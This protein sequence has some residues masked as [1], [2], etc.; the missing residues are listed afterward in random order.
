[1]PRLKRAVGGLTAVLLGVGVLPAALAPQATAAVGQGF[2]LNPSDLR[3]ILKQIK[4]SEQHAATAT[5]T[6]PCGT[7][8]GTGPDQIPNQNC[9]GAELPWGLRTVDGTLQQPQARPGDVRRR[10]PDLPADLVPEFRDADD[11]DPDGPGRAPDTDSYTSRPGSSS[12]PSRARS[13]N[14]IVDQ[15]TDQPRRGRRRRRGPARPDDGTLFIPN[16]APDVGLSAPYNSWFTLFGQFFDHGLDLTNK[17]GGTVF[18]PLEHRRPAVR[19][20]PA[21][22]NFMVL[23]RAEPARPGRRARHRDDVQNATNQTTPFVDQSQTYTSH[24]SHQVFLR[25]YEADAAGMP[26]L[27]RQDARRARPRAASRPGPRSRTQARTLLGIELTDMDVLNVPLLATDPYGMF[28][29]GANGYPQIVLDDNTLVEGD[30]AANGGTGVPVP[31]ERGADRPRVPRRHR[32]PRG[33]RGRPRRADRPGAARPADPGHRR[34]HDRR[35]RLGT[36]D[37]EMLDAHFI[38]GDGRDNE[39]IGLTA[40]HN[41]FHAEHNRLVGDDADG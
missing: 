18:M 10:R 20:R 8:L 31:D 6:N 27:D 38:T 9:Q 19:R 13:S 34:R 23:T 24:P 35:R 14:L 21:T 17:G 22:T 15:T 39:N 16:V 33:A 28:V 12:T 40:V 30:P 3:F 41:V 37:D 2:N 7:L 36:Y 5:A 11:F 25:E 4:I 32:A 29:R 1:M 26:G